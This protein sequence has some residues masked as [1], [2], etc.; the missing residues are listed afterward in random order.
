MRS[1]GHFVLG[2]KIGSKRQCSV[3]L[4]SLAPSVAALLARARVRIAHSAWATWSGAN[5]LVRL[6][7]LLRVAAAAGAGHM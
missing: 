5:R 7:Q 4:C 1:Y 2:P 3:P 6:R